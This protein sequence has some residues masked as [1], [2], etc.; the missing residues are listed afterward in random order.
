MNDL[1]SLPL[2]KRL[3][4]FD[5]TSFKSNLELIEFIEGYLA[6]LGVD[7]ILVFNEEKTKANLYATIGPKDTSGIMLSGHTDVVPIT[8]QDWSTD[9]FEVVQKEGA[10]YGRGT[11]DMKSF[12]AIVLA[13]VPELLAVDIKI[14]VHLA[15]S[16]DEEI[17]CV[18][19]RR[20][21]HMMQDMPVLPKMCVVG[22]PTTMQVVHAHKG[23]RAQRVTVTGLEAHSS[24]PH[25]GVNAVDYAAE[26]VVY[27]RKIAKEMAETGPYEEGFEVEHTT[28]HVGK[29]QG[30]TA[31][32]IVPKSCSFD[33]EIRNIP[34]HD[35]QPLLDR[36][37][38][39][40]KQELEPQMHDVFKDCGIEFED[41]SGYPGMFTP[42]DADVVNFV[43]ALTD[44]EGLNKITF[45]TEGGLF[46]ER[47]GIPTVVC[48]PGNIEQAHKPNE[49]IAI[50]Q[51][52]QMEVFMQRLIACIG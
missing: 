4:G 27:I 9:P 10:L 50:E 23:K 34:A 37:R 26:M 32:N 42:A 19:V 16:Y 11:A 36:I 52:R 48:G 18:G 35:P 7:S 33:F 28:L 14:P 49:F 20:L 24:L 22:E 40:A 21:L 46:T 5:T 44:V 12:I 15:F 2:I 38:L 41:L 6:E 51:V 1:F 8:G 31:L 47:V 45:G 25:I 17:G 29:I 43:K 3:I 30:G 39:Y 13:Y